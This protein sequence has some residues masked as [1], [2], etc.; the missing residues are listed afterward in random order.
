VGNA[1]YD[2]STGAVFGDGPES[3]SQ[4]QWWDQHVPLWISATEEGLRATLYAW[5]A[6]DV[7][8]NGITPE[9]CLPFVQSR[10]D[11]IAYFETHMLDMAADLADGFDLGMAYYL[12]LDTLGHKASPDGGEIYEELRRIDAVLGVFLAALDGAG[13]R[14]E[15]NVILVSDHGMASQ[16]GNVWMV[17]TEYIDPDLLE[18]AVE[19]AAFTHIALTDQAR[20]DEAL[21]SLYEWQGVDVYAKEDIPD[22]LGFRDND[23]ILDILVV[24]KGR[25]KVGGTYDYFDKFVP[26]AKEGDGGQ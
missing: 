12:N 26:P 23:L 18:K 25:A 24:S 21:A 4:P 10:A 22:H 11:E 6:C 8:F 16:R 5:G 19:K 17:L 20:L 13:I 1:I 3:F 14:G 7:P 2:R 9:K 15:T